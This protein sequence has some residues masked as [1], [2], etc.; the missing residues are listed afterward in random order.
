[1]EVHI[2]TGR[3]LLIVVGTI[4]GVIF[5][6]VAIYYSIRGRSLTQ[7]IDM[8]RKATRQARNPWEYEDKSLQDLSDLVKQFK[9]PPETG[10]VQDQPE[11]QKG[12]DQHG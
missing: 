4:I 9:S 12:Q 3:A 7:Q 6:N 5:V 1:M 11:N 10:P 2:N 8:L